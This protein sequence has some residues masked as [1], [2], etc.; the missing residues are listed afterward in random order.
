MTIVTCDVGAFTCDGDILSV[1]DATAGITEEQICSPNECSEALGDCDTRTG[2]VRLAGGR[3]SFQGR[4]E[5]WHNDQWG[6]VC[7]DFFDSS[8]AEVVCR[9]LE[10]SGGQVV[11]RLETVDGI[12][13]IALDD[14]E[15]DG[16]ETELLECPA[17]PL[18]ESDCTHVEDV[19]VACGVADGALFLTDGSSSSGRLNVFINNVA[20]TVCDDQFTDV[21]AG[22][23]CREIGYDYGVVLFAAA[24]E[25]AATATPTH[26]DDVACQGVE[27]RL[28]VGPRSS[29]ENCSHTEDVGV[30]CF[31]Y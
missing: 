7:D 24:V 13:G 20:G 16:T 21:D 8:D 11:D 17:N 12:D 19:G 2:K 9:Q 26:F 6:T 3:T 31:F 29:S 28:I 18:G 1:C 15:C 10:L 5:V 4:L 14:V 22:V 27:E 23:A 30:S 25:D